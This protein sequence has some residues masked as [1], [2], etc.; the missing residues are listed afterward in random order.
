MIFQPG[1]FIAQAKFAF[2]KPCQLQL[3]GNRQIGQRRNGMVQ[4]AML[5]ANQFQ[6]GYD[7]VVRH[8]TRLATPTAGPQRRD[9][10]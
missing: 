10:G 7:V 3:V 6:P 1:N 9:Y 8:T 4:V 5:N 2:L